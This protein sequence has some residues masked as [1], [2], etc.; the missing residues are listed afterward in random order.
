MGKKIQQKGLEK[1]VYLYRVIPCLNCLFIK[2][3]IRKT[4]K[5]KCSSEFSSLGGGQQPYF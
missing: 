3:F 2:S 4:F 5:Y 1:Y